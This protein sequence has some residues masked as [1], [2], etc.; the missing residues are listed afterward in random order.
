MILDLNLMKISLTITNQ[1]IKIVHFYKQIT[2][3]IMTQSNLYKQM[4]SINQ[5]LILKDIFILQQMILW[6][7]KS[8]N[9]FIQIK[10]IS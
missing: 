3:N 1:I 4:I 9:Q 2:M 8:Q 5:T 6:E 7:E 10:T